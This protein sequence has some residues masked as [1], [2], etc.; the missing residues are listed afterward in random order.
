MTPTRDPTT[1]A[2]L[3]ERIDRV[4]DA[5]C[6]LGILIG[7]APAV[8]SPNPV[9]LLLETAAVAPAQPRLPGVAATWLAEHGDALDADRL[10]GLLLRHRAAGGAFAAATTGWILDAALAAGAPAALAGA[11]QVAGEVTPPRVLFNVDRETPTLERYAVLEA[12]PSA[13]ARGL[14]ASAIEVRPKILRPAAWV[15]AQ[16]PTLFPRA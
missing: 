8:Q 7:K 10:A 16:N 6:R 1:P 12:E 2:S 3:V 5:W 15:R 11:A 14:F 4:Q 9:T 13:V